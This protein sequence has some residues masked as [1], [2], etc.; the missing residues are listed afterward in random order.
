VRSQIADFLG[1]LILVYILIIFAHILLQL[2]FSFG[3]RIPYAAWSTALI[4]F[5]RDVSEPY[6]G[7]FRRFIPPI[8]PIDISPL[9]AVLVLQIVG[10]WILVPLVRG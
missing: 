6:L 3:G 1:A 2:I 9:V 10:Y 4:G 5:L 8:G 7:L